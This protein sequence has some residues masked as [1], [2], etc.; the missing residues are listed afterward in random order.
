MCLIHLI[1]IKAGENS[2]H[3]VFPLHMVMPH[4][5]SLCA[6]FLGQAKELRGTCQVDQDVKGFFS[7]EPF[8]TTGCMCCLLPGGSY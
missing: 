6:D 8:V 4:S 7:P 3:T 5:S 2:G 1:Q